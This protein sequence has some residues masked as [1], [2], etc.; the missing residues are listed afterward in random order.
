MILVLRKK[1]LIGKEVIF[2]AL[3]NY[4]E[5]EICEL[6]KFVEKEAEKVQYAICDFYSS[7]YERIEW[8]NYDER[9]VIANGIIENRD[10]LLKLFDEELAYLVNKVRQIPSIREEIVKFADERLDIKNDDQPAA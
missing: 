1:A 5:P 6:I 8:T 4:I 9:I 10:S 2:M 7:L 3:K